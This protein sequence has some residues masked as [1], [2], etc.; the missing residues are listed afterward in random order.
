[1]LYKFEVRNKIQAYDYKNAVRC[2][3]S[4][5]EKELEKYKAETTYDDKDE[6]IKA[7]EYMIGN[8]K[9][10]EEI[11]FVL[12]EILN[13]ENLLNKTKIANDGSFRNV[14]ICV[15]DDEDT[16]LDINWENAINEKINYYEEDWTWF[17]KI[18]CKKDIIKVLDNIEEI[19]IQL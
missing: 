10:R 16:M 18:I 7:I 8:C 14:R 13:N 11:T 4:R 9:N 1:M 15:L 12:N 2:Y 3:G 6:V 17:N 5:V 19:F